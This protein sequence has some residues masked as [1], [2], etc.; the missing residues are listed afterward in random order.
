MEKLSHLISGVGSAVVV[1]F[2]LSEAESVHLWPPGEAGEAGE[3]GEGS[4]ADL[5]MEAATSRRQI[6]KPS[7]EETA[8]R[9]DLMAVPL[10]AGERLLGGAAIALTQRS[11]AKRRAAMQALQ[12]GKQWLEWM[13]E[14]GS[15]DDLPLLHWL[16]EISEKPT[17]GGDIVDDLIS[18]FR[19]D[20][21]TLTIGD[22]RSLE[23]LATRPKVEITKETGL[24]RA[25]K[26]AMFEAMDQACLLHYPAML[27]AGEKTLRFHQALAGKIGPSTLLTLPLRVDGETLGALLLERHRDEPFT[28]SEIRQCRQLTALAGVVLSQ[29]HRAERPIFQLLR[30]RL[31][32]R[33]ADW[34]GARTL[35]LKVSLLLAA[36]MIALLGWIDGDY[37]INAD[38][39]LEGR[40]QRM[41]IAPYD[42]YLKQSHVKAGDLVDEGTVLCE[43]DDRD[44]RLERAKWETQL[45]KLEKEQREAMASHERARVAILQAQRQEAQAELDLVQ[46]KVA[47]SRI[48]APL[49]GVVVS[50][51]LSQSLGAPLKRGDVLFQVAPLDSYRV[52][53]QV[54]ELD[55]GDVQPGQ[56]GRLILTGFPHRMH[57]FQVKR[58]LPLSTAEEGRH[59]FTLEA[60]LAETV[61]GLR[62]GMQ[63]MAK[64]D[65]GERSLLWLATHRL[66]DWLRLQLWGWWG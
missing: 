33:L 17:A 27:E 56:D 64:I 16:N 29:R 36:V 61:E 40:V 59:L 6:V 66:V 65:A 19:C 8:D 49:S 14:E 23:I 46:K 7:M 30:E 21:A 62:P 54:D 20:R 25:F 55:I 5:A 2:P 45:A 57:A 41:V 43:L 38:A 32:T 26:E 4:L 34:L 35:W 44:L 1:E 39:A 18:R 53:L 51:D 52:M 9:P 50:G 13:L 63:G 42:G 15:D 11:D 31:R 37:R 58:V 12:W 60:E 28:E 10:I 24:V 47:R 48:V 22:H 3:A